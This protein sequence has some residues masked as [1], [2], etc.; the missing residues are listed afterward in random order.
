[1]ARFRSNHQRSSGAGTLRLIIWVIA[2]VL[3]LSFLFYWMQ[4]IKG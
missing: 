1:M 3:V 2:L 4:Q